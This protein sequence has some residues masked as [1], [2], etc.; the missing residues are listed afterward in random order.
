MLMDNSS[1]SNHGPE[2]MSSDRLVLINVLPAWRRASLILLSLGALAAAW[3]VARWCIGHTMAERAPDSETARIAA[4][5]VPFD[6]QP[7]YSL[8]VRSSREALT[9]EE[10][11]ATLKD[12]EEAVALSPHDYRLWVE[13][14]RAREQAGDPSGGE[15]ALKRAVEL[16]PHYAQPRWMLGNLLL[17]QGRT[18]E[19]FEQLK[20]AGEAD[21]TLRPQI[22]NLAWHVY[23]GDIPTVIAK[24]GSSAG[25]RAQLVQYLLGLRRLDDA[26][27]L[28]NSLSADEK[29][30]QREAGE[31]LIRSS[32]EAKRFRLVL[33]IHRALEPESPAAV[34]RLLNGD[35]EEDVATYGADL[36][37]WQVAQTSQPQ[38]R[39]DARVAYSGER[40]LRLIFNAPKTIEFRGVS[41]FIVVE[42]ATRYRLT[43]FF[44]TEALKSAST[45]ITQVVD[46]GNPDRVLAESAPVP[47]GTNEWQPVTL[48]FTTAPQTEAVTVRIVREPCFSAVCPIFG[49]IWYDKFILEQIGNSGGSGER[50]SGGGRSAG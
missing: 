41:Q 25:A 4:R 19:A 17:R 48:D 8:A 3:I 42:P 18:D 7:Y 10:I 20:V 6:P 12:Y 1:S 13:L 32:F 29:R 11:A 22:F 50:R 46:A 40:S 9:T 15:R 36:F 26:L 16:A 23:D 37:G 27:Q 39:L 43:Y 49:K 14:G 45:L 47:D 34:G 21:P 35:F 24:V 5:L 44:R 2:K 28:W 31:A 33:D 38:I 30:D